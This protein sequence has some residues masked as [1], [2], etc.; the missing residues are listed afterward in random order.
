[1]HLTQ[2][3][4]KLFKNIPPQCPPPAAGQVTFHQFMADRVADGWVMIESIGPFADVIDLYIS[5]YEESGLPEKEGIYRFPDPRD[6]IVRRTEEGH[7]ALTEAFYLQGYFEKLD[8]LW[9]AAKIVPENKT[10]LYKAFQSRLDQMDANEEALRETAGKAFGTLMKSLLLTVLCAGGAWL[11]YHF[12]NISADWS[13]GAGFPL[14]L[15]LTVLPLISW[16]LMI[17]AGLGAAALLLYSFVNLFR[18]LGLI[19]SAGKRKKRAKAYWKAYREALR[20]VRLR[21]LFYQ[22]LTGE[23][24]KTLRDMQRTVEKKAAP[25]L[26]QLKW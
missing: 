5:E 10:I 26:K 1:M 23:E 19:F 9:D 22:H 16:A 21:H 8:E 7:T 6:T 2:L 15:L 3:D 25:Y 13:L 12:I 14:S 24:S 18:L 11:L 20:Y 17:A 4:Q